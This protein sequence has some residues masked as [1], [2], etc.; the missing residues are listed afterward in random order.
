VREK[1]EPGGLV[2]PKAC[3]ADVVKCGEALVSVVEV[4]EALMLMGL[5]VSEL[6]EAIDAGEIDRDTCNY[7]NPPSDAGNRAHG[8]TT[9]VLR[10]TLV[11]KGWKF[12]NSRNFCTTIS[13]DN[14]I[15]IVVGSGDFATGNAILTPQTEHPK[16]DMMLAGVSINQRQLSFSFAD[17]EAKS[18]P[19]APITWVLLRHRHEQIVRCELSIPTSMALDDRVVFKGTRI[20]LPNLDLNP[21]GGIRFRDDGPSSLE[22]P[23]LRRQA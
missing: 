9:R 15:E 20:I 3:V 14:A 1:E 12:S 2:M 22:V 5:T 17:P 6:H 13:P 16:G 21:N 4:N 7:F 18:D 19:S 10:E 23:V 8:T 11:P